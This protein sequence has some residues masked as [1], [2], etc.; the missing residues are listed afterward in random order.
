MQNDSTTTTGRNGASDR[1]LRAD[2]PSRSADRGRVMYVADIF[3][4]L[5]GRKSHDWIKRHFAPELRWKVGRDNAWWE[6]DALA[7]LNGPQEGV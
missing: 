6:N 5:R 2:A 7:W 3:E 4:L 1:R